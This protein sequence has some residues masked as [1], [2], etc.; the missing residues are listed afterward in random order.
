MRL[1]T[2]HLNK[3]QVYIKWYFVFII[4][5]KVFNIFNNLHLNFCYRLFNV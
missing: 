3:L 2:A 5:I 1:N 4:N